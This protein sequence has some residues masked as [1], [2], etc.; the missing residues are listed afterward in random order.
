MQYMSLQKVLPQMDIV[1]ES[2]HVRKT[3]C[4]I[5][6]YLLSV[7]LVCLQGNTFL[8]VRFRVLDKDALNSSHAVS[9]EVDTSEQVEEMFDSVSYEKVDIY[10]NSIGLINPSHSGSLDHLYRSL[11]VTGV[12]HSK[13]F[14]IFVSTSYES[15]L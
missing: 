6:V 10:I 3:P 8:A 1:S 11:S 4:H 15:T 12:P 2:L 9:T 7:N 13:S 5:W 14:T